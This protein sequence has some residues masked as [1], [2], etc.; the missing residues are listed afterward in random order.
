MRR[1]CVLA[2]ASLILAGA[3]VYGQKPTPAATPTPPPPPVL[4]SPHLQADFDSLVAAERA[5]S[6]LCAAKGI[7]DSFLA[8]IDNTGVLFRPL[9]VMGKDWLTAHP[10]PAARLTWHPVYAEI[11]RS[12]DFGWTTGPYEITP[13]GQPKRYGQYSTIW[14]KQ[15]DGHWKFLADMGVEAPGPAPEGRPKLVSPPVDPAKEV[16]VMAVR[17]ALLAADRDLAAQAAKGVAAAYGNASTDSTYL[18]RDG[19]QPFVGTAA[20][21]SALAGD[22]GGLTWESSG[23]G[24]SAAGDLGFT[25]GKA[26]R[27]RPEEAGPYLRAWKRQAGGGWKLALDVMGLAPVKPANGR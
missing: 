11:A 23:V 18:L 10:N 7:K 4:K 12:G 13:Q 15:A 2:V 21:R 27:K 1:A 17:E 19:H 14:Q 22:P 20:V 5:F 9:S 16:D 26:T 8:N 25:Y 24:V 6:K 3:G